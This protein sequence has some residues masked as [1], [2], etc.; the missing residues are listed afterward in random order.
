MVFPEESEAYLLDLVYRQ[1]INET[2]YDLLLET[3]VYRRKTGKQWAKAR[4][5]KYATARCW[6]HRAELAIREYMESRTTSS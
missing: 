4:G 5:V 3:A 6:R 1:V 2:Q